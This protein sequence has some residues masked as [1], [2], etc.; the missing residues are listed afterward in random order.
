MDTPAPVERSRVFR[1][2]GQS[3]PAPRPQPGLHIVATPIGNLGDITLRGLETLAGADLIACEDTRVTRRL[4]DRYGIETPLV[5]YHD[6]NAEQMRPRI[7]ARLEAGGMVALVSDAGTPLVSDPGYKLVAA[8]IAGNHRVV[9]LPGASASLAALVA[10]GLPTD[11][12]F[13]EGFLP[14]KSGARQT[15]IAELKTLPATLVIYESGPRLPESLADL[16]AGLG[17]R[18]A[19]VCREL[20]KTFEEVRRAPLDALAGHYAEVGAPKGEIVLVI[21]PPLAEEASE[22]D[23]DAALRRALAT[24]SVKDAAASVAVATGLPRRAVYAR[25]LALQQ[26]D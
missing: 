10:A 3:L 21:G 9:P 12:F 14:P 22:A 19:A 25:A 18:P 7:L 8:A 26:D 6:H 17:P 15:R 24:L 11:R 23:V 16:A 20:T 2:A 13:F 5:A 4:L 1:L